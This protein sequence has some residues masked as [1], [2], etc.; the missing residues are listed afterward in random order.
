MTLILIS[1][2]TGVAVN[3]LFGRFSDRESIREVKNRLQSHLLELRL[4]VNEPAVIWQAQKRL[5]AANGRYL[6]LIMRPLALLSVPM[7]LFVALL[8]PYFGVAPLPV[9]HPAVVTIQLNQ[10]I[11]A[12]L[13]PP[14]G[15]AVETPAVRIPGSRQVSWRIRPARSTS[16]VLRIG[17]GGAWVEKKI[18]AGEGHRYTPA[19]RAASVLGWLASPGE[20]LLPAGPVDWIRV[21]YPEAEVEWLGLR[22]HWLVWF[23]AVSTVAAL[24]HRS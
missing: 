16:G 8:D 5:I 14:D 24:L 12:S 3:W 1:A 7:A 4:F 17:A 19:R 21:G 11:D 9:G 20:S 15:I 23:L 22:A 13:E 6:A 18:E 2:I 10:P